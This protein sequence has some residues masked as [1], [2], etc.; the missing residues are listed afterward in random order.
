MILVSKPSKPFTYTAKNTARR[1]AIINDYEEEINQ[2]Y[3]DVRDS[4]QT[5]ISAPEEWTTQSTHSFVRS[6]VH[7][8]LEGRIIDDD[9]D[10]FESGGDRYAMT[11]VIEPLKTDCYSLQATWIRNTLLRGLR[12]TA[13]LDTR[14]ITENFVYSYPTITSLSN[15]VFSLASGGH[16]GT[17]TA[18]KIEE[19]KAM[20][21][22]YTSNLYVTGLGGINRPIPVLGSSSV[23]VLV[24]STGAVGSHMLAVLLKD[25]SVAHVYAL[26]RKNASSSLLERQASTFKERGLSTELLASDKLTLLEIDSAAPQLRIDAP[27]YGEVLSFTHYNTVILNSLIDPR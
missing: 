8:V 22:K 12:E 7:Q 1:Q 15:Y 10:L 14:G 2:V 24:G 27:T 9:D 17:S 6:V 4:A 26:N 5:S 19:M 3:D 23:V 25:E 16:N 18:D 13:K 11:S 20:V 21:S